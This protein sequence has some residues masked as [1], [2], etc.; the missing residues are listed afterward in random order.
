VTSRR[1]YFVGNGNEIDDRP[2]HVVISGIRPASPLAS[3]QLASQWELIQTLNKGLQPA[4]TTVALQS[5]NSTLGKARVLQIGVNTYI[6]PPDRLNA[7]YR[8]HGFDLTPKDF[9]V[10]LCALESVSGEVVNEFS[11]RLVQ[12][13]T[14]RQSAIN[15]RIVR[16]TVV[17]KR[18]RDLVASGEAI[19]EGRC[20][21]FILPSQKQPPQAETLTLFESLQTKGVPFRRA[22]ADDP[23]E[24]SIPDQLPS[25][26]IA[27]GGRPHRSPTKASG[28]NVWTIG[29]DLGHRPE[30]PYSNLVLTL[31]DPDGTLVGAWMNQQPRDET[32]R[33]ETLSALLARCRKQLTSYETNPCVVVLRDGRMFENESSSLYAT[34]LE[35][36]VSLFEY[37]KNG[38]PQMAR[39]GSEDLSISAPLAT[40]VPG[41]STMFV[42]TAPPRDERA[43][44]NV[45]KVTW[46][47]GWNGLGLESTEIASMLAAAATAPGLGLHARNLPA[48][49]YWADG[50]AGASEEDL[51]FWGVPVN[52]IGDAPYGD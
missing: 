16:E 43:L 11:K 31:V 41:E 46:R 5:V 36:V 47:P 21:L 19:A 15:V 32:A 52:R 9:T 40:S 38:N 6:S 13:A 34:T 3:E 8:E 4:T 48:A 2:E 17:A 7:I 18:V 44:P 12:A 25:L 14:Q 33:V 1:L 22:Y 39:K 30:R 24:Y 45:A 29:V 26:L 28:K 50:V 27:A 51:R 49:I 42:T 20:V 10:T 23:F 35:T 37:R